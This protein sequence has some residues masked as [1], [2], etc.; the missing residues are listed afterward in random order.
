ML[1]RGLCRFLYSLTT[2]LVTIRGQVSKATLRAFLIGTLGVRSAPNA[3]RKGPSL[4]AAA[5]PRSKKK[6]VVTWTHTFVCL[7]DRDTD[8]VPDSSERAQLQLAGL[9]EK[10]FPI[11]VDVDANELQLVYQY[12]KLKDAGGYELLRNP[13]GGGR[14]LQSTKVPADGYTVEFLRAVVHSAKL[15]IR[16]LQKDLDL[17]LSASK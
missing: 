14:D 6:K 15:F 3:G 8:E 17:D 4:S 13:E 16:P 9:G 2:S 1:I 7:A 12:P 5:R 11:A 10:R